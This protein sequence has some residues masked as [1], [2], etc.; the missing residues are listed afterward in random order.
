MNQS[1]VGLMLHQQGWTHG[2]LGGGMWVLAILCLL[3]VVAL[4]ILISRL[5]RK[6]R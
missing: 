3:A 1:D 6:R 4:F 5:P 2:W